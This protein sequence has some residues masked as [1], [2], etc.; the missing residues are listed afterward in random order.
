MIHRSKKRHPGNAATAISFDQRSFDT[1]FCQQ[2]LQ[3]FPGKIAALKEIKRVLRPNGQLILT[4]WSAIS[5]FNKAMSDALKEHVGRTAAEKAKASFSFRDG[6]VI[7]QLLTEAGFSIQRHENIILQ[8]VFEDLGAQI[9]ALP[10]EADMTKA[11]SES[12]RAVID[13]T[14]DFLA[15]L[16]DGSR[17][18]VPQETHFFGALT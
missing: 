12:T 11:G 1:T 6:D 17:F 10:V 9:L 13:R 7:A 4:C 2:R 18:V 3:F 16:K 15:P 8:R 5:P 14:A